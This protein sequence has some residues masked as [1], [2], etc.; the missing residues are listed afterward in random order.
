M[1]AIY[2]HDLNERETA[3]LYIVTIFSD[4]SNCLE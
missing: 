1:I 2:Y 3:A 4:F